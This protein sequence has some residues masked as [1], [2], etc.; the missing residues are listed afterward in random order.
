MSLRRMNASENIDDSMLDGIDLEGIHSDLFSYTPSA[1]Q[2][3][4]DADEA[5]RAADKVKLAADDDQPTAAS[6]PH[7]VE[8]SPDLARVVDLSETLINMA[9]D[10]R[11][12][13]VAESVRGDGNCLFR[14]LAKLIQGSK[15]F[16]DVRA[17]LVANVKANPTIYTEFVAGNDIAE[18]VQNMSEDKVVR[19]WH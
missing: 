14:A 19:T 10:L 15:N 7:V 8:P 2:R 9:T 11:P 13:L 5:Q 3:A 18:W 1:N 17:E 6:S 16:E 12:S 4:A